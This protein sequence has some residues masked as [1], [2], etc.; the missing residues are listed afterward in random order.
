LP[1]A[2]SARAVIF[3]MDGVLLDSEPL[4]LESTNLV[5]APHG[6][7]LSAADNDRYIGWNERAYWSELTAMFRLPGPIEPYIARR[8]EAVVDLLKKRLPIAEGV[9]DVLRELRRRAVPMAVASSSQ[10]PVIEHILGAGGLREFFTAIASGDEVVRSK[11]DP[12]IFRLAADRLGV[13][14]ERCIVLEDAPHGVRGALAAG[15]TVVRVM[16]ETTRRL[17]FP[18]LEWVIE[19]FVGLDVDRLLRLERTGS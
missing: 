9:S 13:A 7:V 4:H 8:Q 19:S 17:A 5:L 2:D 12:E 14:P 1:A 16:T 3:D 10:R 18:P 11:P 15:M 6:V